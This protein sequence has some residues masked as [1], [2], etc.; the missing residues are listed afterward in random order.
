MYGSGSLTGEYR[1]ADEMKI[2][3]VDDNP[4]VLSGLLD[5]IDFKGLGFDEVFTAPNAR[6]ARE[7]LDQVTIEILITDI[8]MR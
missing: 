8:E 5:G 2:L 3:M 4:Y 1:G 7:L 6:K